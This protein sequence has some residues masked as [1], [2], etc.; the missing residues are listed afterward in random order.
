MAHAEGAA[1]G[2]LR[3]L[4]PELFTNPDYAEMFPETGLP[5]SP[6]AAPLSG[7]DFFVTEKMLQEYA[8]VAESFFGEIAAYFGKSG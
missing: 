7:E 2:Q 1:T 3:R 6:V 4:R 5:V 8:E